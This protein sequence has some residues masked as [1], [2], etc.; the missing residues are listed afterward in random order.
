[1]AE[2]PPSERDPL[3]DPALPLEDPLDPW[4]WIPEAWATPDV[5]VVPPPE[6][7]PPEVP[8]GWQE[9]VVEPEPEPE[10]GSEVTPPQQRTGVFGASREGLPGYRSPFTGEVPPP[11]TVEFA[12]V[13]GKTP[14]R[15]YRDPFGE[16]RLEQPALT[17]ELPAELPPMTPEEEATFREQQGPDYNITQLAIDAEKHRQET[18]AK[19]LALYREARE[20]DVAALQELERK[21][22]AAQAEADEIKQEA[23]RLS[24]ETPD[25]DRWWSS[26]TEGQKFA[27][28]LAAG[29]NGW[30]KPG[31]P[32]E[33]IR[34]IIAAIDKDIQLQQDELAR[35]GGLLAKR[36]GLVA[37][38]FERIRDEY[39]AAAT[40]RLSMLRSADDELAIQQQLRDPRGTAVQEII[41]QRAALRAAIL[42]Q[43]RQID[44]TIWKR[45]MAK[46]EQKI[47]REK[48]QQAER[49]SKRATW[50][51]GKELTAQRDIAEA[52]Q[53][54]LD[55]LREGKETRELTVANLPLQNDG[56]KKKHRSIAEA[57]RVE[58]AHAASNLV[59]GIIDRILETGGAAE[60]HP[61]FWRSEEWQ[62]IK[63]DWGFI[64]GSIGQEVFD[65]G[66]LSEADLEL[67]EDML[68]TDDP[69]GIRSAAAGLRRARGNLKSKFRSS[70]YGAGYDNWEQW[71]PTPMVPMPAKLETERSAAGTASIAKISSGLPEDIAPAYEQKAT[72]IVEQIDKSARGEPGDIERVY[73]DGSVK[74]VRVSGKEALGYWIRQYGELLDETDSIRGT[75]SARHSPPG[76][77]SISETYGPDNPPPRPFSAGRPA[78]APRLKRRTSEKPSWRETY[79]KRRKEK[80]WTQ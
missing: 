59:I 75:K 23:I 72:T 62:Q 17:P 24:E 78:E 37:E 33:T 69:T 38:Q 39:T 46:E 80:G 43:E 76:T 40:A 53:K 20:R 79:E 44:E 65:F 66:A 49:A 51:R 13:I 9:P 35:R 4:W 61:D 58:K 10:P 55:T 48:I 68:G 67:V 36:Q 32:N 30:L 50:M 27:A 64:K 2:R 8:V 57:T 28:Y 15:A 34:L 73:S 60:W 54:A 71:E 12:D 52:R 77:G 16:E 14:T 41:Q 63:S 6:E 74:T 19:R 25:K 21:T 1:M 42:E 7:V 5:P 45:G 70:L 29:I 47:K 31:E 56:T 26:R 22:A 11:T 3:L 18:D